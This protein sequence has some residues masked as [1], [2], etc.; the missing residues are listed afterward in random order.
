MKKKGLLYKEGGKSLVPKNASE[1][2]RG[3]QDGG[4]TKRPNSNFGSSFIQG[5]SH[6]TSTIDKGVRT[7]DLKGLAKGSSQTK[8]EFDENGYKK[9]GD[10]NQTQDA[11]GAG[12]VTKRGTELTGIHIQKDDDDNILNNRNNRK[13]VRRSNMIGLLNNMFRKGQTTQVTGF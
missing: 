2:V 4:K 12:I 3:Y 1:E 11:N 13:V 7:G 9:V 10:L 5:G 8:E 6:G